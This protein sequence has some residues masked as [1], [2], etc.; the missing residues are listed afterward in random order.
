MTDLASLHGAAGQETRRA[1]RSSLP[2]RVALSVLKAAALLFAAGLAL[3]QIPELTYDLGPKTPVEIAGPDALRAQHVRGSTFVSVAGEI[4]LGRAFV[5]QTHGLAWTYFLVKPY[6]PALVVRTWEP[7]K[8][9]EAW[10]RVGR[11]VGR[12]QPLAR[13]PFSRSVRAIYRERFGVDLPADAYFLARDDVPALS[14]WQVGALVFAVL[15]EGAM[16]YFFYFF[17]RSSPKT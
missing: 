1:T 17:R 9:D 10:R 2:K 4:D 16:I 3:L 12:L 13:M 6:G 14:G 11:F 8:D 5:H 7:V 15:L